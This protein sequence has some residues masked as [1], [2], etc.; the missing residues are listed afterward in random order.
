MTTALLIL[1]FC[2]TVALIGVVLI[3]RSEGGGLGIGS[4]QGMGAFMSGR[5]TA[6]L[7]TRTTA[8]LA[9]LF[10]LLSLTLALLY[11]G[12]VSGVGHDI[13]AQP[14]QGAVSAPQP[15]PATPKP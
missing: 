3:Q 13:L 8:V 1:H 2:V 6:N 4:S 10:M 9:G 15:A 12:G 7:L 14:P 5:G 11:R